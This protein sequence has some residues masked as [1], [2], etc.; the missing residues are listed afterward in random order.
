MVAHIEHV[1]LGYKLR[2]YSQKGDI[3]N[4][5]ITIKSLHNSHNYLL[6]FDKLLSYFDL[7]VKKDRIEGE[8]ISHKCVY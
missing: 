7:L 5:E 2:N 4:A 8:N 3:L 6:N 1:D